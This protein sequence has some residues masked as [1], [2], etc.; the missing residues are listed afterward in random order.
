MLRLIE[1]INIPSCLNLTFSDDKSIC[2]QQVGVSKNIC[3]QHFD[4]LKQ[5]FN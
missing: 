5:R 2:K 1:H 4:H 3:S